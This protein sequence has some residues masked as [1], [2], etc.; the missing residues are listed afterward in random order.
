MAA[1]QTKPTIFI[2]HG[3]WHVPESY[4]KLV[5]ALEAE[6]YEV[7]IPRLPSTNQVRPPNADLESDTSLIRSYAESLVSAGRNVVALLHSYGGH[8]G[9]NA[10][11][12]LGIEARAAQGLRGGV[13]HLIYMTAYAVAE[14]A[15]TMD[16]VEKF[17][18]MDLVPIAF[19]IAEDGTCV[20]RN[21]KVLLVGPGPD[22]ADIDEYVGT[23]VR[24]NGN[25]LYQRSKHAAWREIPVSFIYATEDMTIPLHYQ[26]S[27]VEG[28]EKAGRKVQTYELK[29]GHCPNFTA[30]EGVVDV[31]K[32]TAG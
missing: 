25:T 23:F 8:V 10:L 13:S 12:G 16:T 5:T 9:S 3:G 30:T 18:N 31:I 2:V 21:P 14:G 22:D 19:D 4:N 6:G 7:H 15:A 32:A 1:T 28:M 26:K 11:H 29:S 27:F 17:G 20:N 24:W